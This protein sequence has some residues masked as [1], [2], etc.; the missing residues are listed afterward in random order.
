MKIQLL[1]DLHVEFWPTSASFVHTMYDSF[2]TDADVLVLAGDINVGR[3]NTLSTLKYFAD[4]YPMVIYVMG[5]HEEYGQEFRAFHEFDMFVDKLPNNVFFLDYEEFVR[6]GDVVFMGSCLYTN[7][8]NDNRAKAM[9]SAY[10]ADFRL[11]K[12][13]T[14]TKYTEQYETELSAIKTAYNT[15]P[16]EKKVIVTHFLPALECI[17]ERFRTNDN[18]GINKYFANT[19]GSYI[20]TLKDTTWLFGHTHDSIDMMIGDT[21][22]L[23]NP[24]GY[25]G[26]E[27]NPNFNPQF[28]I[29]V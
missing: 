6:Y 7:F 18:S 25:F 5:N 10:I 20:E 4:K 23:C 11:I 1:S 24:M 13:A 8:G 19:L 17:N 22:M 2:I 12:G 9:A 27:M 14:P 16:N 29:E 28:T 3:S 21:K 26:S 15:F